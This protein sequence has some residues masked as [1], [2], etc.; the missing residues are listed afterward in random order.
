MER[1]R[2]KRYRWSDSSITWTLPG[3]VSKGMTDDRL[4][5]LGMLAIS[6]IIG[7]YCLRVS[8]QPDATPGG[9]WVLRALDSWFF[10]TRW[11]TRPETRLR[12]LGIGALALSVFF[13]VAAI[14]EN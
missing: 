6:S 4:G 11:S 3:P 8:S 13:A 2:L 12:L 5:A 14:L 1:P 7:V 9:R 10:S